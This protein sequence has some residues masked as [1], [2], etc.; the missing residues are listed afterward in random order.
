MNHS[1]LAKKIDAICHLKGDFLLR[2][3]TRSHEYFDKY[4]FESQPTLLREIAE[5]M[6]SLIPPGTEALAA[7]E[8]GGI[9]IGTAL[10]LAT[11][12]PCAFIRK[13]AKE[14]GTCQFAEGFEIKGKKLCLIEDVITSGGQ[15][16]LSTD[17]LRNE[18]AIVEHVLCVINRGGAEAVSKLSAKGLGL[19]SLFVRDDF[20]K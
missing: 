10:S 4:R 12:I 1:E 19:K 20:K 16:L 13:E 2:S 17:D 15:V 6:K 9:P 3:G 5:Q 7:L 14:Y 11:G 18:G 8:M